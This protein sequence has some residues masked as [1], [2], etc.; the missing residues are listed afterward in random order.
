MAVSSANPRHGLIAATVISK[1]PEMTHSKLI[2]GRLS[3][4]CCAVRSRQ[5]SAPLRTTALHSHLS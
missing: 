3:M 1:Y 5:Q 4:R 2:C